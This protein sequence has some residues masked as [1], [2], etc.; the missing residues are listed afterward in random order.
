MA[1]NR[2]D[3]RSR[4][5]ERGSCVVTSLLQYCAGTELGEG[6][7][8]PDAGSATGNTRES[9]AAASEGELDAVRDSVAVAVRVDQDACVD[10][11]C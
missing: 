9:L 2:A 10:E 6:I 7:R 1:S 4:S 11:L 8:T 5:G 3:A